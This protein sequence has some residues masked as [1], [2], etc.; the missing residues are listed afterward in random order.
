MFIN[1]AKSCVLSCLRKVDNI[2]K[3]HRA[4]FEL[5]APK[6]VINVALGGH[7]VAMVLYCVTKMIMMVFTS[8]WAFFLLHGFR[9]K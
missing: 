5:K 4:G 1:F 6:A 3:F 8:A 2:I 7:A 9:I